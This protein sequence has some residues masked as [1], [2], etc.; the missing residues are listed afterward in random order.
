MLI[1][2]VRTVLPNSSKL[3]KVG[4]FPL[5][6]GRG[7]ELVD[8]V[9]VDDSVV[10][11]AEVGAEDV[12]LTDLGKGRVSDAHAASVLDVDKLDVRLRDEVLESH[13]PLVEAVIQHKDGHPSGRVHQLARQGQ[14]ADGLTGKKCRFRIP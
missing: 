3:S 4:W 14:E 13:L 11:I 7:E 9:A 8:V 1:K 5:T 10:G 12:D 2:G 6:P